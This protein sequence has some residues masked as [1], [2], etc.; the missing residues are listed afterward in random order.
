[1]SCNGE[2]AV[3]KSTSFRDILI[4]EHIL[5]GDDLEIEAIDLVSHIR[6]L[7]RLELLGADRSLLFISGHR[8]SLQ[9]INANNKKPS[10]I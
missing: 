3:T 7:T 2:A 10:K 4:P 5:M 1:M 8:I 6:K 9:R